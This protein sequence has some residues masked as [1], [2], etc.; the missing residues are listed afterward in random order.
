MGPD[1]DAVLIDGPWTHREVSANG[2]RFHV[3][4]AGEG[5][6][7][8]LLHGF[9]EFWWAWRHQIPALAEA[10]YRV[11]A[12]DLRGYGGTDKPP[13]GYDAATLAADAAG[14]IR[15]L[16]ERDAVVVGHGIGGLLAWTMA[17]LHRPVVRRLAVLGAPHP[18]RVRRHLLRLPRRQVAASWYVVAA[19]IPRAEAW[20]ARDGGAPVIQ[21]ARSWAGPGW[22]DAE[23]ERRLRAAFLTG[24]TPH[25]AL[26]YYR[27]ATRSLVRP[28]GM[29]YARRMAEP[30]TAPVLQVHGELDGSV[31]PETVRGSERFVQAPY[32]WRCLDGVGHFP[33]EEAPEAVNRLLVEWAGLDRPASAPRQRVD[34]DRDAGGR[35]RNNRPRDA[36][37]RPLPHG[38]A[39]VPSLPDDASPLPPDAAGRSTRTRCSRRCG[40]PRQPRSGSCGGGW[41]NSPSG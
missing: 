41:P 23:T 22:P 27:W 25:C 7:I 4:E 37:G 19:Q 26:E 33:H 11:A 6:L 5:P 3:A 39:G 10:G 21:L 40:R 1:D 8:L 14:L 16:G 32:V 9:P 29:R 34:R 17:V 30:V 13:R 28:D 38:V 18:L 15:A 20:L 35:P 2:A 36:T 12:P 24:N 31:L